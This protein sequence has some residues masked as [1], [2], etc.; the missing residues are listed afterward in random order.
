MPVVVS[1]TFVTLNT[2][3]FSLRPAWCLV[4][5]ILSLREHLL[6]PKKANCGED[7]FSGT[8]WCFIAASGVFLVLYE[9]F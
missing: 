5:Q 3:R 9:N 2:F 4:Y 7:F 8:L 6:F 1:R